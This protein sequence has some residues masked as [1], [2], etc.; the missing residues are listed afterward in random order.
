MTKQETSTA[1]NIAIADT[2]FGDLPLDYWAAVDNNEVPWSL[3]KAAKK[4]MNEEQFG[5]AAETLSQII[6]LPGLESRQ[7]LQACYFLQQMGVSASEPLKLY[8]VVVEVSI[9]DGHDLLA[10]YAD[11]SAR[12]HNYSGS[13]VI[14][15]SHDNSIAAKIDAILKQGLDIV[16][17]IGPWKD[18]RPPAPGVNMARISFLTSHGLHFGEA[19]QSVLF[20]DP[21][22]KAIMYAML[23]MMET[24][25]NKVGK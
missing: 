5:D 14:W 22:S 17:K 24:L 15:D 21:M 7:Y 8:G 3:F 1:G 2:L 12:Y 19:P 16:A 4:S 6:S 13:A 9:E 18:V 11:H 10:V 20:N 23:D 25:I